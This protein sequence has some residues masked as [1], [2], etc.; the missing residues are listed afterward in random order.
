MVGLYVDAA[1]AAH[2]FLL[3]DGVAR[4]ID[5]SGAALTIPFGI[6][7]HGHI[8][9]TTYRDPSLTDSESHGFLLRRGPN[10]PFTP[11][12]FPHAASTIANGINNHGDIT[13]VYRLPGV[14][15]RHAAET[16]PDGP[17]ISWR[18]RGSSRTSVL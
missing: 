11:I 13:G 8:V 3:R 9:G 10:G 18:A 2:G 1:G 12:D 15:G 7:N 4:N 14:P 6:N 16:D 5:A 17:R